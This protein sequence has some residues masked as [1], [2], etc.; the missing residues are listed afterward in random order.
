[1][2]PLL[3]VADAPA[4]FAMVPPVLPELLGRGSGRVDATNTY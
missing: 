4:G 2:P 1:L 3:D